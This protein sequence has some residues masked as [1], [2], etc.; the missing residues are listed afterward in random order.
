MALLFFLFWMILNGRWTQETALIGAAVSGAAML[1]ACKACDWSLRKEMGLY[2][3]APRIVAYCFTVIWEIVKANLNMCQ[4]VYW[5]EADA[6]VRTIHTK[7]KSRIARMALAN[8]ITLTPGTITVALHE[9]ELKVHC[10]RPELAEGLDDLIFERKL[11]KI[12]EALHG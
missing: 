11:L 12:E 5:G 8:A 6:V 3:A 2:R 7:L 1:F 10:L 9:D 4:I